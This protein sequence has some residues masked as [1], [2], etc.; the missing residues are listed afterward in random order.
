MSLL[1]FI[2][3]AIFV[4]MAL[5]AWAGG[6]AAIVLEGPEFNA[7]AELA[8]RDALA[9]SGFTV[10]SRDT[11][12]AARAFASS[13]DAGWNEASLQSLRGAIGCNL[14]LVF[15]QRVIGSEK[16]A[17]RAHIAF[18]G[19]VG[20]KVMSTEK[21]NFHK[22]LAK[23]TT[24]ILKQVPRPKPKPVSSATTRAEPPRYSLVQ[25]PQ[26]RA[27]QPRSTT[28]EAPEPSKEREFLFDVSLSIGLDY[29]Q[30]MGGDYDYSDFKGMS[31]VWVTAG[32]NGGIAALLKS[33]KYLDGGDFSTQL[34][35]G[36]TWDGG[37]VGSGFFGFMVVGD[38]GRDISNVVELDYHTLT[39]ISD[40]LG[41]TMDFSMAY[42]IDAEIVT[43]YFG[44]GIGYLF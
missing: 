38:Y 39:E 31:V 33:K 2:C 18:E 3:A 44:A 13:G 35:L 41:W 36:F 17:L 25:A 1:R 26:P 14:L 22:A 6:S 30:Y 11:I 16:Y 8:I 15:E 10:E 12:E 40:G 21:V 4:L 34:D 7:E 20:S 5:P 23:L 42:Y 29:V 43:M 32:M 24:D 27:P 28:V 9:P 19:G 37:G